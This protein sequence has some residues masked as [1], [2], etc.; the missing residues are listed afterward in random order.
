MPSAGTQIQPSKSNKVEITSMVVSSTRPT[1]S[2]SS[3]LNLAA[4]STQ[5]K[6][7]DHSTTN[8]RADDNYAEADLLDEEESAERQFDQEELDLEEID[9]SEENII[10]DF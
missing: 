5:N 7:V 10:N 4:K 6:N 9:P 8:K 3:L 2:R 1:R